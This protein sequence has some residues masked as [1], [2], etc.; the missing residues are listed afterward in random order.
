MI[1]FLGLGTNLGKR[2]S[3]LEEAI[4]SIDK[5]QQIRVVLKSKIYETSP[6]ENLDQDNFLNQVIQIDTDIKPLELLKILKNIENSMGRS[7]NKE[8]YMPRIIDLDILAYHDL[9]FDNQ[10]LSIPHP[11]IKFRKF[12]LKPWTDIAPNYILPNSKSTIKEL[13]DNVT[14]LKDEVR[15]YN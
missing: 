8:K 15:K 7:K 9:L 1:V 3:N 10:V 5:V 11:K 12:I 2:L 4:S 13:L 14:H 6:M